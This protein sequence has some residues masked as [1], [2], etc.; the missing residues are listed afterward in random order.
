LTCHIDFQTS[1]PIIIRPT[2]VN[3][4][5]HNEIELMFFPLS[6]EALLSPAQT[7]LFDF[8]NENRLPTHMTCIIGDVG[9]LKTIGFLLHHRYKFFSKLEYFAYLVPSEFENER[10]VKGNM[11][12]EW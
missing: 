7:D 6:L 2:V 11:S 3:N 10:S 9:L 1:K 5:E 4:V 8:V 12:S